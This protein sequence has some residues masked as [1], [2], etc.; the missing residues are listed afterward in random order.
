MINMTVPV[1]LICFNRPDYVQEMLKAF[2]KCGVTNI[3]IFK[4][5]PRPNNISDKLASE[6]IERYISKIDWECTVH[7]NYMQNNLG[8]GYGPFSAISWAFQYEEELIILEDDCIP[9]KAFFNFCKENLKRYR[10]DN[11]ISLISGFSR[12]LEPSL[13]EGYDYIFSNYGVTWGWATWKRVWMDFDLQ[14]RNLEPFF[15]QGGFN[16]Q[17]STKKEADFF[18]HR[19]QL[20]KKDTSLYKHVWDLQFGLY[21]RINGALRVVPRKSLIKYIGVDGTHYFGQETNSNVFNLMPDNNYVATYFPLEI[22][23][24]FKYDQEYFNRYVYDEYRIIY[25]V[26]NKIRRIFDR[27]VK[28]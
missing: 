16:T 2:K 20:C 6:Q 25:R 7:T 13:F 11:R 12:L 26:I 9:T 1:L 23:S 21:S 28:Y 15:K 5:G 10:C 8:C 22:K 24:A 4:D 3:Y 19:Y 18:N 14:L 27:I 17:F